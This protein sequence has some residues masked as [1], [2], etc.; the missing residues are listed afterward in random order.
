MNI[1]ERIT[2][3]ENDKKNVIDYEPQIR[4]LKER[5]EKLEDF[6]EKMGF[7]ISKR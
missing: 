3:L 5:I 1:I 7:Y 6:I 2:K 4:L